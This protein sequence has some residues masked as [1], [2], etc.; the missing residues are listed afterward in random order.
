MSCEAQTFDLR[1]PI[2][3]LFQFI[4]YGR[5][6]QLPPSTLGTATA[7]GGSS[8]GGV[9][10]PAGVSQLGAPKAAPPGMM[11]SSA[12]VNSASL[13]GA[14]GGPGP[15]GVNV[16]PSSHPQI[17]VGAG[18]GSGQVARSPFLLVTSALVKL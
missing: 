13:M 4:T 10:A 11:T 14:A 9:S 12:T 6:G 18:Q 15:S 3:C 2:T 5:E 7:P 17:N 1:P 8:V 16:G